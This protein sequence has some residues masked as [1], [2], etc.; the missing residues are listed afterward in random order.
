[1]RLNIQVRDWKIPEGTSLVSKREKMGF[2]P[3]FQLFLNCFQFFQTFR[4]FWHYLKSREEVGDWHLHKKCKKPILNLLP[5]QLLPVSLGATFHF[6]QVSV[7]KIVSIVGLN[8]TTIWRI[9]GRI[10]A[11]REVKR[12][13]GSAHPVSVLTPDFLASSSQNNEST[14]PF[15]R[16]WSSSWWQRWF[17]HDHWMVYVI[18]HGFVRRGLDF[19]TILV[20]SRWRTC[21]SWCNAE[22]CLSSTTML[23]EVQQPQQLRQVPPNQ[24]K[25]WRSLLRLVLRLLLPSQLVQLIEFT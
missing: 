25:M 20:E 24:T 18:K 5:R 15:C 12:L 6:R 3:I 23:E 21:G 10:K 8:R 16:Q 11:G 13:P 19:V 22:T 14:F 17:L 9:K 4:Q 7:D 1:M 2:F